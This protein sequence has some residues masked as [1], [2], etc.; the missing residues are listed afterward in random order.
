M[1]RFTARAPAIPTVTIDDER[2]RVTRWDFVPGA[3]TGWHRHHMNYV[4]VPITDGTMLIEDS[5]GERRV[6]LRAGAAY[7]RPLGV[8]HNV[9]NGGEGFMSFV[10]IELKR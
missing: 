10:E 7:A 3:E 8:E 6:P 5:E 1:P 9:V 2:T 4:V